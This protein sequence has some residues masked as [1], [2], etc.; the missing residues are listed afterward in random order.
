M[1]PGRE[2]RR[3]D[4]IARESSRR[5]ERRLQGA[6]VRVI[7]EKPQVTLGTTSGNQYRAV[8]DK[9]RV[10]RIVVPKSPGMG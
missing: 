8:L 5:E 10:R 3:D 4:Y 1:R 6:T 2:R 7:V 9:D